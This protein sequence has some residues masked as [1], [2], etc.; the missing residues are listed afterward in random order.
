[1]NLEALLVLKGTYLEMSFFLI[2]SPPYGY[3]VKPDI[4]RFFSIGTLIRNNMNYNYLV[5]TTQHTVSELISNLIAT[6][7]YFTP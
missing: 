2:K 5:Q 1:M 3:N 7:I 4:H 6:H